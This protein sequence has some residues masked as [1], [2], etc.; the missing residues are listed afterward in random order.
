[1]SAQPSPLEQ[2]ILQALG[3]VRDP[4]LGRDIVSLGF[5][6]RVA[7]SDGRAD[8]TIEL[9]TP[10]CP[11]KEK[12]R[13]EAQQLILSIPGISEANVDMTAQVRASTGAATTPFLPEVKNVIAVA[14]GKGGVGKSTV[15][16]NLALSLLRAGA[17]VGLLDADVYGPSIPTILGISDKPAVTEKNFLIPVTQYGL[18][19]IS[20]GFFIGEQEAVIWR[21]PMLS[22]LLDQFLGMVEWGEL[23]YMVVDLPPG[24]GDIQ[25]SLCQKI[26]LAGAVIVSTPQDVATKVAQKAITMFRKL[27][28]PVLGV[29]ENMSYFICSH[30]GQREDIFGTGG[31][32]QAAARLDIPFLGRIPLST[33]LRATSDSGRPE[34][35]DAPE[36]IVAKAFIHAAE[37]LAAQLSIAAMKGEAGQEIKISF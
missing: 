20:V 36:S 1:M 21:G 19:V 3:N 9:T 14:S 10:A 28:T 11:V 26:P 15:S 18:K 7:V 35:V 16:A 32:E 24:T 2:A 29:I 13:G 6:K 34:M 5:V 12:M 22:K 30:C 23:D 33:S 25:L 27:N 4:D 8:V 31:A 17:R 37:N